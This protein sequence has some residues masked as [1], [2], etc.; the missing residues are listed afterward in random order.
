M[1]YCD[2][3]KVKIQGRPD[4][5]PLCQGSLSGTPDSGDSYPAVK[6]KPSKL[7]FAI[8]I[9]ALSSI[10]AILICFAINFSTTGHVAGW[11]LYPLAGTISVW[12]AFTIAIHLHRNIEK[13]IVI[14]AFICSA[15][16]FL[17]DLFTGYKGWSLDFV[18]PIAACVAMLS[19]AVVAQVLKLR[20][21]QYIFYLVI[22][23][24]IGIISLVLLIC[25]VIQVVIPSAICVATSAIS[26]TAL[27]IFN[28]KSLKSEI[29][30]RLHL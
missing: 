14:T 2:K 26:L 7:N 23:I 22:D 28:G 29:E 30:R 17:W 24:I 21:Q 25:G 3:C 1:L 27:L 10:A 6:T 18:L 13:T 15:I 4:F 11:W 20:I 16:S 5:C 8:K 12:I 9:A 19:M